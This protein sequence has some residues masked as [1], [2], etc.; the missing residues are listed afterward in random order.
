MRSHIRLGKIFG[1]RVGLHFSWFLI[2]LLMVFS[3]STQFRLINPAWSTGFILTL[4]ITTAILFFVSLLLHE[5]AHSLMARSHGI[6]VR[7]ITLF[8]LGGVSQIEGD[9]PDAKTEFRIAFVGPLTSLLIGLLCLTAARLIP[10]AVSPGKL[11]LAWLGFINLSL[12]I[13]NLIPGYPLD[14]GRVLRALLWWKSGDVVRA[15]RIA[16]ATGQVVGGVFIALGIVQFFFG[17]NYGGLWISFIGWFLLMAAGETRRQAGLTRAI[18]DV[19]VADI[20]SHDCA[21]VDGGQSVQDLVERLFRSGR[22]CFLVLE[23]GLVAGLVTPHEI[24]QVERS[25]WPVTPVDSVMRPLQGMQAVRPDA[26]LANALQVMTREN[27]NQLPVMSDSHLEGVLSRA[28][29]L[30][31]LQTRAELEQ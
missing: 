29:V 22:R 31:Y 10:G 11:M 20:M 1:I 24:R 30:N 19:R 25:Q 17:A 6:P 21:T 12:A 14:G 23:D 15:T 27:V 8:A 26:P 3:L 4:A 5:L 13:F 2:A 16:A 18:R 28:E 9:S 7:E